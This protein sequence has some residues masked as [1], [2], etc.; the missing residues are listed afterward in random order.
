MGCFYQDLNLHYQ[1][2][3]RENY[4]SLTRNYSLQFQICENGQLNGH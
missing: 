2:F 4:Y 1:I 3:Y